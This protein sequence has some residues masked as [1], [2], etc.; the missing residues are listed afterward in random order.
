MHALKRMRISV[1][2][3]PRVSEIPS[4]VEVSVVFVPL[5]PETPAVRVPVVITWVSEISTVQAPVVVPRGLEVSTVRVSFA[6]VPWA[7]EFP[8]T[9]LPLV[10]TSAL[11]VPLLLPLMTLAVVSGVVRRRTESTVVKAT[12]PL[13]D[14]S[15]SGRVFLRLL[16]ESRLHR[17]HHIIID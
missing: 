13:L 3:V 11:V 8:S 6:F 17:L 5:A 16:V 9:V 1:A 12:L 4:A 7:P 10:V 14:V 2:L 15:Q